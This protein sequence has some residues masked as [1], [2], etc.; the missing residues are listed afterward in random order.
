M[1]SVSCVL[2]NLD[3]FVLQASTLLSFLV[4][5]YIYGNYALI[6]YYTGYIYTYLHCNKLKQTGIIHRSSVQN[7]IPNLLKH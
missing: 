3:P 6:H 1:L 4:S 7:M 5:C 2:F